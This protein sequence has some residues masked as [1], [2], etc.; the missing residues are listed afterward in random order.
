VFFWRLIVCKME[1]SL[2]LQKLIILMEVIIMK[3]S[4]TVLPFQSSAP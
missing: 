4:V 3:S 1:G 2:S